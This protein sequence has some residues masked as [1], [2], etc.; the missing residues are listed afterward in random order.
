MFQEQKLNTLCL[1]NVPDF[2]QISPFCES[3]ICHWITGTLSKIKESFVCVCVCVCPLPICTANNPVYIKLG[4]NPIKYNAE[5]EDILISS[6]NV[7]AKKTISWHCQLP[8][9]DM[10]RGTLV[11]SSHGIIHHNLQE[12]FSHYVTQFLVFQSNGLPPDYISSGLFLALPSVS[13][14]PQA[15]YACILYQYTKYMWMYFTEGTLSEVHPHF[16]WLYPLSCS[17][18]ETVALCV[19]PLSQQHISYMWGVWRT[20]TGLHSPWTDTLLVTCKSKDKK[21]Q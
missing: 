15:H 13:C 5:F 10:F 2:A 1:K 20:F 11:N 12:H 17:L 8:T 18:Q 7:I 14:V 19:C 3:P 9:C 16:H 4:R 21:S 6:F